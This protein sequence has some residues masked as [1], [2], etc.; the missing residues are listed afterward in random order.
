[1]WSSGTCSWSSD[2][3]ENVGK[4]LNAIL[5]AMHHEICKT[6]IIVCG[7]LAL[8]QMGIHAHLVQLDIL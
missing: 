1:M 3:K 4:D 2:V 6:N 7:D 8:R 5:V